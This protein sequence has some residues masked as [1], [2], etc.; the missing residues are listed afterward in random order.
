M[1]KLR[2]PD[3]ND[4]FQRGYKVPRQAA[5]IAQDAAPKK[6]RKGSLLA[7][8]HPNAGITAGYR[9]RLQRLIKEMAR[10]FEHWT[11]AA[12]RADPP[13]MATDATPAKELQSA[14]EALARRWER[15]FDEAAPKLARYFARSARSRSDAAL[16]TILKD[17]GFTV[18][19]KMTKAMRDVLDATIEQNVQLIK[20]IPEQYLTQV[21]GAVMRSVQ[22]GRDVGSLAKE[23]EQEFGVTQRRAA[24][25]ALDQ[26]NKAT[27]AMQAVRQLEVGGD[28]AEAVWQHSHGGRE[29]RPTHVANSGK[30]Y[31]VAEGWYDPDPKVRRR[32]W[33]GELPRCRCV[34]RMVVKGFS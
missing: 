22:V 9:R 34:P 24:F 19:F 14:V 23:L 12:Y 20:S 1:V 8:V 17:G 10:S 13:I 18:E 27:S 2:E 4:I 21:Q 31:K 29:P 6:A 25:I 26:N 32:I 11:K 15:R 16:K 28:Q 3:L 30:R 5:P 7:A 33:P